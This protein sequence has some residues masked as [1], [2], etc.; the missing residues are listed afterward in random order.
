MWKALSI[1]NSLS[2][3]RHRNMDKSD[4][5]AQGKSTLNNESANLAFIKQENVPYSK[6]KSVVETVADYLRES[7]IVGHLKPGEK[8]LLIGWQAISIS[9]KLDYFVLVIT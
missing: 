3:P 9:M 4:T 1:S 2:R 7:I 8:I 5:V 6:P